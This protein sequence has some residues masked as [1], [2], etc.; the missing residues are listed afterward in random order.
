M[1]ISTLIASSLLALQATPPAP[2]ENDMPPSIRAI[3][4]A[5]IQADVDHLADDSYYGRYWLSPFARRAAEWI[6]GQMEAAGCTPVLPEDAWF[7]EMKTKDASPN[8]VGV[9]RGTDPEAGW[10]LL[11]AHYDH[12]PPRRRGEDTI[13]NGAD[14]NASGVAGI[15]AVARA[16]SPIREQLDASVM[17]IAFTGEEAGMKGS[18][19]FAADSPV[20][21]DSVIGLF[22]MDMISRGEEDLIFIDGAKESPD[23]IKALRT[24]NKQ[25]GLRLAVDQHPDWL[26]RS[27]QWP[28]L[29]KDVQ[30]MLFSVEDHEDY[31]RVTDHADRI[32]APLAADVSRLVALA[33]LDLANKKALEREDAAK[34]EADSIPSTDQPP[35]TEQGRTKDPE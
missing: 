12:L 26:K 17:F 1:I 24:A 22:N 7:Q 27:D 13:F 35:S 33:T 8:V 19:H 34:E 18:R 10:V 20:P 14:D 6:K 29:Q 2:T 21:L 28:F 25:V 31:H 23:L 9:I 5:M 30:A 15:L 16:L 32:M 3:T 4:P 11:G